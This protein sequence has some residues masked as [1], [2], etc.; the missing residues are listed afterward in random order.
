MA[1]PSKL[2]V[3]PREL[4]LAALRR[5]KTPLS[6]YD[7]LDKLKS[8][9]IKGPPII[10]RALENLLA[11]G[12]VHKIHATG[13]YIA[14]NCEENHN[15]ELSVLTICKQCKDVRELHDHAII[16]HLEKLRGMQVNLP[17]YAVIELPIICKRC[18][19]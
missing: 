13:A 18:A 4:I 15:H 1:R 2:P 3:H 6:A 9:G 7:L 5:S 17:E 14:C 8:H 16:H 11:K 12:V 19:S 10:Y